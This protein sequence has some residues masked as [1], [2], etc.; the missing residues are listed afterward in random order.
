[1]TCVVQVYVVRTLHFV[2]K[3]C[4]AQLNAQVFNLINFLLPYMFRAFF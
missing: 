4:N 1:M 2:I 3:L